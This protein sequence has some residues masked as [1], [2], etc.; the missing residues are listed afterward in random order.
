MATTP[1]TKGG[2]IQGVS[3]PIL[4]EL[5]DKIEA[6]IPAN[7][8]DDY[9]RIVV[10]GTKIIV[11]E[12]THQMAVKAFQEAL[13]KIGDPVKAVANSTLTLI[14][15]IY[16]ESRGKMSFPAATPAAVVLMCHVFE[17]AEKMGLVQITPEIVG[18]G[19]KL[20]GAGVLKLFGVTTDQ[21]TQAVNA[22]RQPAG[23]TAGAP[24]KAG[25]S[26]M[27]PAPVAGA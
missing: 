26:G 8:K 18:Q 22:G 15:I 3:D 4:K 12:Q 13:K 14:S 17:L 25:E 1:P 24:A 23:K 16:R 19:V 5:R 20:V 11:S 27:P 2:M 6:K 9:L 7:L 10:A 21:L